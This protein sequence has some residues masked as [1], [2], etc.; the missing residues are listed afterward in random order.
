MRSPG[1]S[2]VTVLVVWQGIALAALPAWASAAKPP[3]GQFLH[4]RSAARTVELTMIAAD[5]AE[6]NG[7]NFDGY[8][9]GELLVRVPMGWRVTVRFRNVGPLLN[10][11]AVV[12]GPGATTVAF[13][14]ASTP[15]PLR[16]LAEGAS[17]SFSFVASRV[18]VFRLASVVPGHEQARMWDVLEV[19]RGG[20][21]SISAR[22][23][24]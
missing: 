8:G 13:P 4:V 15:S 12:T 22:S 1:R 3:P 18:G 23:G 11:C 20:R 21:P 17:A 14:G 6:N 5:T 10:S 19:Q 16:G 24:P 7:F 9:R 2:I